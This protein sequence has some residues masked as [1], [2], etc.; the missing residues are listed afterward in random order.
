M[1]ANS[2]QTPADDERWETLLRIAS[3][4][5]TMYDVVTG[6]HESADLSELESTLYPFLTPRRLVVL[7]REAADS[8]ESLTE[9]DA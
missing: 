2:W 7:L 4:I 6:A 1:Y 8:I 3:G 9:M 5:Q